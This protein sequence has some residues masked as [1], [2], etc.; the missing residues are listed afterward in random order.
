MTRVIAF[1]AGALLC[2]PLPA[3]ADGVSGAGCLVSGCTI[4]GNLSITQQVIPS[5]RFQSGSDY[6]I[7]AVG[8]YAGQNLPLNA[9][10]STYI[11]WKAGQLD[12]NADSYN[13]AAGW[14][15]QANG[16]GTAKNN[17][18]LGVNTMGA[19]LTG[20]DNVFVGNDANRNGTTTSYA[21]GLGKN[22]GRNCNTS[23]SV[24]VG[25]GA[26]TC[27]DLDT[28]TLA[29]YNVAF[30]HLAMSALTGVTGI[31]DLIAIGYSAMPVPTSATYSIAI[32]SQAGLL[33]AS[34]TGSIMIGRS[35]APAAV[36]ANYITVVGDSAGTVL[37]GDYNTLYGVN[38][39][40]TL[41]DGTHNLILGD[42]TA[43]TT[44]VH[45]SS[46]ILIGVNTFNPPSDVSNYFAIG[47]GA[48]TVMS[49]TATNTSTPPVTIPGSLTVSTTLLAT[50]SAQTGAASLTLSSSSLGL[51]VMTAS[52]SAPGAG[53]AKL[54]LVCNGSGTS[55]KLIM[56]AG[57][58]T[59]PVNVATAIGSGVT[60][61]P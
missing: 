59:T 45:G 43:T 51:S 29:Q 46:N 4:S 14:N 10:G 34:G 42:G 16:N 39:G 9:V 17:S 21:V 1:F 50:T 20:H 57:T 31:H 33:F 61:C 32:G 47:N 3:M 13:T 44:L 27:N 58:S 48:N 41:T 35:A 12:T 55:A 24:M 5:T 37:T 56:Y 40:K 22:A 2:A 25:F 7:L 30:G 53:G 23:Y 11:G 60:G 54:E 52:G 19:N 6:P 26:L 18:T 49:A 28:T 8:Q 15:S 36:S 38:T